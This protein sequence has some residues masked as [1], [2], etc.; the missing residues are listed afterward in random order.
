MTRPRDSHTAA[1]IDAAA[2]GLAYGHGESLLLDLD[3][4]S[5]PHTA[6]EEQVSASR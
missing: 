4:E 2:V 1:A 5:G 3:V 6:K